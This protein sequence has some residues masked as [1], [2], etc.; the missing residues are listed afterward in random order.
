MKTE[1]ISLGIHPHCGDG[2]P[3]PEVK[4]VQP[5]PI[6]TWRVYIRTTDAA[7]RRTANIDEPTFGLPKHYADAL[8]EFSSEAAAMLAIRFIRFH[9]DMGRKHFTNG[10]L[11]ARPEVHAGLTNA[12]E[13]A[14][15]CRMRDTAVWACWMDSRDLLDNTRRSMVGV[16]ARRTA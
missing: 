13:M 14:T 5:R 16:D 3:L 1:L 2:A 9:T 12:Q 7:L 6:V 10:Q 4:A 8:A 15:L 11:E